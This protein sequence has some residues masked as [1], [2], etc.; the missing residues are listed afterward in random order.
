MPKKIVFALL[1]FSYSTP[2]LLAFVQGTAEML[3]LASSDEQTFHVAGGMKI[4]LNSTPSSSSL[5]A[6]ILRL[7]CPQ[8]VWITF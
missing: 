8:K 7:L 6:N 4:S 1:F 2:T 5:L 3:H